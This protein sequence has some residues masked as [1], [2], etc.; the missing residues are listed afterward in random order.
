MQLALLLHVWPAQRSFVFCVTVLAIKAPSFLRQNNKQYLM[1]EGFNVAAV[2]LV[3]EAYR[4][5]L[6]EEDGVVDDI[7]AVIIKLTHQQQI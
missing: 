5:W 1:M 7:T 3:D 4:R 2:Q 6:S